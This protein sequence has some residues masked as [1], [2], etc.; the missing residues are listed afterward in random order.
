MK[1]EPEVGWNIVP[2]E[3]DRARYWDGTQWTA[4]SQFS[5]GDRMTHSLFSFDLSTVSLWRRIWFQRIIR[6]RVVF[7]L[8]AWFQCSVPLTR[9]HLERFMKPREL[10]TMPSPNEVPGS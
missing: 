3:P 4:S 1:D 2:G 8:L 7:H 9:G 5:Q 6:N 10:R